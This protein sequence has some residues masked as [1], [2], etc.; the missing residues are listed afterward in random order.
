VHS[1]LYARTGTAAPELRLRREAR[2]RDLLPADAPD[3]LEASGVLAADGRFYVVCDNL[4]AVA[5]IDRDLD[6]VDGNSMIRIPHGG[7]GYEDLARDPVT[8]H[9]Y[10]L[11][12][13]QRRADAYMARVEEYDERWRL[14]ADSWLGAALP[15]S[16]KGIEGLECVRRDGTTYLLG[17][18]EGNRNRDGRAGQRPGGGRILVFRRGAHNWQHDATIDLPETLEFADY[19][20]MSIV[21]GRI[22]VISQESSALWSGALAPGAWAVTGPGRTYLFPRD[23]HG[24]ITYCTPEGVCWLGSDEVVVVSDRAKEQSQARRCQDKDQ[25]LHIFA[26]PGDAG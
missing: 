11:I 25:S 9:R 16:N 18:C 7:R 12:E 5:V 10:L 4:P 14:V 3:R 21:D 15:S 2:M 23:A 1:R 20:G 13:A 24:N 26:I 22:A 6:R 19:S 8:G 17:V